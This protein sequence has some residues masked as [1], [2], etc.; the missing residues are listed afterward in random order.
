MRVKNAKFLLECLKN[1][2]NDYHAFS[3]DGDGD[4]FDDRM[5]SNIEDAERNIA[6]AEGRESKWV[7][8]YGF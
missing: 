6:I 3:E 5:A 4:L 1:I 8:N 7:S 2:V